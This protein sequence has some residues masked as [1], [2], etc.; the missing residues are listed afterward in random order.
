MVIQRTTANARCTGHGSL[1]LT[2]GTFST[3]LGALAQTGGT[4]RVRIRV[5]GAWLKRWKWC[6]SQKRWPFSSGN[7]KG[8]QQENQQLKF[9]AYIFCKP[10]HLC[11][12]GTGRPGMPN[13]SPWNC[14]NALNHTRCTS[15]HL[16]LLLLYPTHSVGIG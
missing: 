1:V 6:K 13:K 10:F 14:R 12:L 11:H 9:R 16:S 2:G 8:Q 4:G 15:L 5:S 7:T 3:A